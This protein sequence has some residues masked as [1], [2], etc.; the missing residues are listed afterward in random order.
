MDHRK[1]P[2]ELI[3]TLIALRTDPTRAV[4]L[5]EQL[6]RDSFYVLVQSGSEI[7]VN[8]FRFL[9]YPTADGILGLPVFT[10]EEFILDDLADDAMAVHVNGPELWARLLEVVESKK[11]VVEVDPV[12][13]HGIR[14]GRDM[15]LGMVMKYGSESQ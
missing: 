4:D 7:D 9:M 10:S 5:Y 6:Y 14:L 2:N 11:S 8:S 3:E 12:Q 13:D 15:I 1:S